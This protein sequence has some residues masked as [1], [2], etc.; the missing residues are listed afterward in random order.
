MQSFL[1][2]YG[3]AAVIL[4]A[5][6]EACCI[7][8]PSEVTFGFAGV[9]AYQGHL[10]LPLV[11]ILGTL[12]EL[13]GSYVSFTVGRV[14][15]RPVIERFGRYLLVTKADIDRAERF[16][17]GRGAWAIPVGRA[18]PL[19]RAFTSLVAGFA[20]VRALRFGILSLVG[21]LIYATA[22]SSIGY[23]VGSA[24]SRVEHDLSLA[25]YAIAVLVVVAIVAFVIYRVRELK[26]ESG[27]DEYDEYDE[28]AARPRPAR[29][30]AHRR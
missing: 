17:T 23:A 24:W 19:V 15:E 10:S 5:F 18:L 16:L 13:A 26:R 12:A 3:Y 22:I 14:A 30:G 1:V 28:S 20:G 6:I 11:I 9:L 4:F 2:H 8:I 7:P 21:T 25:G 27:S 29:N